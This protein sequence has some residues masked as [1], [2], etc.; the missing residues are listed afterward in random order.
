M[1]IYLTVQPIE[2]W[3]HPFCHDAFGGRTDGIGGEN[4]LDRLVNFNI[5]NGVDS[6][7]SLLKHD[8]KARLYEK[9]YQNPNQTVVKTALSEAWRNQILWRHLFSL[10]P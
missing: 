8:L 1:N 4:R 3:V 2:Q 9:N 7:L 10:C 5:H 6:T